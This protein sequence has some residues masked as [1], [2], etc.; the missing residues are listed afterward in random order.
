MGAASL[1]AIIQNVGNVKFVEKASGV[2]VA[3]LRG[4]DNADGTNGNVE[5]GGL[6]GNN[7]TGWTSENDETGGSSENDK[8]G[9]PSGKTI[10]VSQARIILSSTCSEK[11]MW[12]Y[13]GHPK[14]CR[15]V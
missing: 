11:A 9:R 13:Q 1:T 6:S 10:L 2:N 12:Y 15:L 3:R 5:I 7:N 14:G 8:N 4:E